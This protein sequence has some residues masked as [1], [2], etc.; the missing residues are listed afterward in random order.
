MEVHAI[1][2]Q[3]NLKGSKSSSIH[4]K[5]NIYDVRSLDIVR[6]RLESNIYLNTKDLH[7]IDIFQAT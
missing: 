4:C 6:V 7:G 1:F 5:V 2:V 3:L